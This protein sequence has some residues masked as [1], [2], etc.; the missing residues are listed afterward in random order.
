MCNLHCITLFALVL[1]FFALVLHIL[2]SFLSQSELSNFF[3]CIINVSTKSDRYT[4]HYKKGRFSTIIKSK[5]LRSDWL[6]DGCKESPLDGW[7]DQNP[8]SAGAYFL[9]ERG[10]D[11]PSGA[12]EYVLWKTIKG[13][14]VERKQKQTNKKTIL[15]EDITK[16]TLS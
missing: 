15:T 13:R 14:F 5:Y 12:M 8:I 11:T 2:H 6:S 7:A 9:E 4:A 1:N 10:R 3:M 16:L